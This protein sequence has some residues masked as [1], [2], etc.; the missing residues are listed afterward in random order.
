[1]AYRQIGIMQQA[2]LDDMRRIFRQSRI[3]DQADRLLAEYHGEVE[4]RERD[5]ID[6]FNDMLDG[7]R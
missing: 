5:E 7:K 2:R 1:M 4:P 6:D 3:A